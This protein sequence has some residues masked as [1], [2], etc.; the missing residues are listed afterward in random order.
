MIDEAKLQEMLDHAAE[1]GAVRAIKQLR[2]SEKVSK[3][4][5]KEEAAEMMHYSTTYLYELHRKGYLRKNHNQKR[6]RVLYLR[7][8]VEDYINGKRE[9]KDINDAG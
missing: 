7:K 6:G 9:V 8:D 1:R 5:T 3:W 4:V 2:I